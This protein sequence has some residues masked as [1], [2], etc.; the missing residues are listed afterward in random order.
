MTGM[1]C[2][3]FGS[4]PRTR[5][6]THPRPTITSSLSPLLLLPPAAAQFLLCGYA[7]Y[8]GRRFASPFSSDD[9][10]SSSC[11]DSRKQCNIVIIFAFSFPKCLLHA[12]K[13][14][15]CFICCLVVMVIYLMGSLQ[16]SGSEAGSFVNLPLIAS[17]FS[18]CMLNLRCHQW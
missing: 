15:G 1:I 5:K 7:S 2:G 16:N 14:C 3:H 18:G 9:A 12:T 6:P 17:C 8:P 4:R 11:D 10:G 13:R